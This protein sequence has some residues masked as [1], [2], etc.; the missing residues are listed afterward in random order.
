M[1]LTAHDIARMIELSAVQAEHN[2]S[3]IRSL[4]AQARKHRCIVVYALP[5]W[6]PL[7][8]ELLEGD[9]DIIIGGAVGFP[10]G[11]VTTLI[12]VAE[13]K[14]LVA[15]GCTELDVVMNI[16]KLLSGNHTAV[17]QDLQAVAET[18]NGL[19]TKAILE[20]H[21]LTDDQI[22]AAS[23]ICIEAGV[24][25]IKTGTGWTPTGA[26]LENI[27]LIKAHVGD[28]IRLKAS[29]GVRGLETLVEMYRRGATRFGVRLEVGV[30][31]IEQ[32]A[33]LPDGVVEFQPY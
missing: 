29:G 27:A 32:V 24:T 2:E 5:S 19:P 15:M 22:R 31:I 18:A 23:D 1:K 13:V 17:L 12:K 20:C 26:T 14:E 4:V 33:A 30:H 16:G 9:P 10:S 28:A 8:R 11:G 25:Y 7:V 6:V 3:H 21:Y